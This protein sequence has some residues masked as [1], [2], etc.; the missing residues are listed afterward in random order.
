MLLHHAQAPAAPDCALEARWLARLPAQRAARL[1]RLRDPADR[2]A[3]LLGLA[4]LLDCA[5]A[6]GLPEAGATDLHMPVRGKPRWRRGPDFS[7][8]H[9]GGR[10]AC[11]LAPAG[12]VVGLDL[13]PVDA[14]GWHDLR[15]VT[16]E[17]E[18]D[19]YAELGL[20]AAFVW[21]AKEAVLKAAGAG[22]AAI[23]EV[24]VSEDV[25]TFRG[26]RFLLC[27]PR[28]AHGFAC[29]VALSDRTRLQVRKRD[30]ARLLIGTG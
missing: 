22:L 17:A 11:A 28:L 12:V 13:E 16:A 15:L 23:R 26:R 21:T 9:A 25:A 4:L 24:N 14:V 27:R 7:I 29:T 30:G 19:L 5:A 2:V 1:A 18:R 10:V 6:A 8:S 20:D 3:T